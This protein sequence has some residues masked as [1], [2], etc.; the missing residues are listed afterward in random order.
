MRW[1]G[2]RILALSLLALVMG[3]LGGCAGSLVPLT[4][5]ALHDPL[6]SELSAEERRMDCVGLANALAQH[7]AVARSLP[8]AAETQRRTAPVSLGEALTRTFGEPGAGLSAYRDFEVLSARVRAVS[9]HMASRSC[10]KFE[11]EAVLRDVEGAMLH[12]GRI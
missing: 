5:G 1:P 10:P 4:T 3:G 12:R 9:D 7:L 8:N 6:P 11:V 2:P